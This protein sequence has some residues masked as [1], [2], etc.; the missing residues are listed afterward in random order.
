VA[1]LRR[2]TARTLTVP[3][4]PIALASH[5]ASYNKQ[6]KSINVAEQ[7]KDSLPPPHSKKGKRNKSLNR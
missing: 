4:L 3:N 1:L 6:K 5:P 7:L 2:S